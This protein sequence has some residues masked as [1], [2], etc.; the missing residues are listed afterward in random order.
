MPTQPTVKVSQVANLE[1]RITNA[2]NQANAAYNSANNAL[3]TANIQS[4]S[5]FTAVKSNHYFL[6]N[7]AATTVTLPATPS[8]GDPVWI[9]VC[10]G[11]AN[12]IIGRNGEKIMGVAENMTIDI[13]NSTVQLRYAN[14]T[15]GWTL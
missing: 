9:T 8:T 2:Y 6:F 3:P 14:T 13:A 15:T 1:T 12:N 4:A 5:S 7:A 11:L 10:N